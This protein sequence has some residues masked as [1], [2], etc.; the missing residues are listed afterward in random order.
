MASQTTVSSG[1]AGRYATALYELADEANSLD[2][3]AR[4]LGEITAMIASSDDLARLIRSP[5]IDRESQGQAMEAVLA[6]AGLGELT[7]RFVGVAAGNRRLF[8]LPAMIDA[9]LALLA[10]RRGE[11]TAE[12]TSANA[13]DDGQVEAVTAALRRAV[14][15]KVAVDLRVDPAILGGLVVRVGSRMFDSSI[16]SKLE[17]MQLAMKGVG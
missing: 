8:A 9:Y 12:V 1:I 17:K 15:S 14:G 7:R 16:R 6:E 13:L 10:K 4:D 2:M 3:V 11:V 5:L